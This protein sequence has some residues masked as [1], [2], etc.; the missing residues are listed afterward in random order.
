MAIS[1]KEWRDGWN[2][3]ASGEYQPLDW[4]RLRAGMSRET[5]VVNEAHADY[6]MP[7]NG[8]TMLSRGLG[9]VWD[10]ITLDVA[11]AHIWVTRVRYDAT[12]AGGLRGGLAGITD[13]H[14]QNVAA[15]TSMFSSSFGF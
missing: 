13:G 3:N 9:F 4:L 10:N 1:N 7:I 5:P 14:A 6:S 12:D 8:R 11:Y 2:F 15:N